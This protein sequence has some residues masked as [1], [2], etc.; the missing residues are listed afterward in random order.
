M[1]FGDTPL[2][3]ALGTV[4][5]HSLKVAGRTLKKGRVL[6]TDADIVPSFARPP[7]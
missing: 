3:E 2:A 1:K 7:A 5:A 6:A 4:L